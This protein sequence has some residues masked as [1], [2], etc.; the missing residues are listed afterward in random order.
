[1]KYA[2]I[3]ILFHPEHDIVKYNVTQLLQSDWQVILIDNSP[4]SH[5]A[6]F[7][8][9]IQYIHLSANEGIAAA[10]NIGLKIARENANDFAMLLDQDSQLTT[11][12]IANTRRR[13]LEAF[14]HFP[15]LAAYGPTIV[16]EFDHKAVKPAI[17][18]HK[19]V[20][21][22]F[23][24]ARQIIASG[25]T[26][27]LKVL[28]DVGFMDEALFIDGVDHEWCWRASV[29]GYAVYIDSENHL[30]H[31][32]GEAR[33]KVL[34]ISFKVGHPIRLYYQYRNILLLMRRSYVPLYWKV[35]NLIAIPLRWIINRWFLDEG[36]KRG[37]YI[38]VGLRDG[39][40]YRKGR[41]DGP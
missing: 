27:P 17:Q 25:M 16:S 8:N 36:Q 33:V 4:Q 39:I 14:Q 9:E 3:I 34:G 12:F 1:M 20:A 40:K 26:I 32:Q 24:K 21:D 18:R 28:D 35:R 19:E 41:Y 15:D 22:D 5:Q 38:R 13:A 11:E 31:R 7:N 29:K 10:Q 6:W 37:R 30:L 2:A 23:L